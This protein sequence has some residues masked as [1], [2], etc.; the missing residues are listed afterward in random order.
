MAHTSVIPKFL[1]AATVESSINPAELIACMKRALISFSKHDG[2]VV[3]PVR[4]TLPITRHQ[5]FLGLMPALSYEE[6]GALGAKL[7]SFYPFAVNA[8]THSAVVLLFDVATGVLQAV[9]DGTI[10]TKMRT[11][12]VSAVSVQ[13]LAREDASVLT[14]LGSGEQARSH[15]QYLSLVRNFREIRIWGRREASA[16]AAMQDIQ[17]MVQT[18]VRVSSFDTLFSCP[19]LLF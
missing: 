14:I 12:A 2:T 16:L 6:C 9:M 11:A 13:L 3:Q 17:T 5:G 4:N 10:L 1:D 7:V 18:H 15:A 8:P 19:R